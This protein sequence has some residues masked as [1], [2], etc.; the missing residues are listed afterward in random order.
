MVQD[1]E[2]LC[3]MALT[4]VRRV[5]VVNQR[6]LL[7]VFG[8]ASEVYD[9]RLDIKSHLTESTPAFLRNIAEMD[10]VIPRAKAELDW[11]R[12]RNVRCITINDEAYPARL[13]SCEDA[14]IVLYYCGNADLNSVRILSM[15]GTRQITEYGKDLCREFTAELSRLC[16]DVLVVSGLA[17]GVDV[18]AHRCALQNGLSTVGVLAHGLDQIYPR[19]HEQTAAEMI[20][21]GGLLTEYMSGSKA[22]KMNFV[23]RNRIVAGMAD[24]TIVV[25]SASKGGSLIT[26]GMAFD[27][28]RE[29]MAFPGRIN[30][31]AS[32]GCNALIR[33]NCASLITSAQDVLDIL[34]WQSQSEMDA[35][36]SKPVQREL[37]L[38]FTDDEQK[39]VNALSGS[40]G[41]SLNAM[42]AETALSVGT[43]SS[44]LLNLE[45]RGVVKTMAG[46][47]Y[48]LL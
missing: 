27:Y 46:G 13:R 42:S 8:S 6:R 11:A 1:K 10:S 19:M 25:E 37:F 43:L 16:P 45:L 17:Y 34:S 48:R 47:K 26:A 22:D 4:Q 2:L 33:M 7:K 5:S 18:N 35:S 3:M 31:E 41:K 32:A 12:S 29:V 38:D 36:R 14:P 23:A 24:A 30:D 21:H 39:I 20:G 9:N 40:D 28:G 44:L 15:V